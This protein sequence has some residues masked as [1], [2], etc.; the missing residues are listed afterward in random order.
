MYAASFFLIPALRW[1]LNQQRNRQVKEANQLRL[2]RLRELREPSSTLQQK[3]LSAQQQA[4]RTVI[5]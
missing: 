1:A 5:R 2:E 3:L 4:R